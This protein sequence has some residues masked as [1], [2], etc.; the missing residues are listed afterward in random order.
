MNFDEQAFSFSCQGECLYGILSLPEQTAVR[1]VLIVVGGPQYRVGSHRQFTLLARHLAAQGMPVM[2]FDY[3][4]MGDSQGVSRNFENVSDDLRAALDAFFSKVPGLQK[5]VIW[6]LCDAASAS[7]F[8]AHQDER[9]DGLVLLNPWVRTEHGLAKAYL[10]RYYLKRV[11]DA[12]LWQKIARGQ[13]DFRATS[14]SLLDLLRKARSPGRPNMHKNGTVAQEQSNSISLPDK[15]FEGLS[16]FKGQVLLILSGDDMTAQEFSELTA[17]SRQWRNLLR[18]RKIQRR[19][20][21]AANHT[22]SRQEWR[23][24]VAAWTSEW[25]RGL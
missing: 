13:F 25:M 9:V 6:G 15:M 4:G 12:G 1:G 2:R 21:A 17:A 20:L 19:R 14:R 22:F 5:V 10:K 23:D 24:Q 11:F 3:R 16:R 18:N 8:Y 7:L